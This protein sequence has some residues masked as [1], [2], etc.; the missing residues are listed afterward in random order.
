MSYWTYITGVITVS[1]MGRTQPEKRYIL[2]TVLAHLPAVTGSEQNM[3][4]H[5]V[6]KSGTNASSSCNEFSEPLWFR[7][8]ADCDGWMRTQDEYF[9][10]LEGELRDRMYEETFKELNKWLNRLAKRVGIDD[11]LVRLDGCSAKDGNQKTWLFDDAEAYGNMKEWPSWCEK[12]SGGEPAWAE[13]LMWDRAKG[14]DYP[15]ML[16]Y[17]Y[18]NDPENDAEVERRMAYDR[19]EE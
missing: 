11:I 10:V 7:K 14:M 8:D 17:K 13:Y 5:V 12:E 3:R 16:A 2:D 1:P 6:Q 4:V 19:G 9:L 15:M 18:Y